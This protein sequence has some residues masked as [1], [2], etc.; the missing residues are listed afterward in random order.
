MIQGLDINSLVT[1]II[2]LFGGGVV[3]IAIKALAEQKKVNA[4]AT[5]TNIKSLLEI[6]QRMNERMAKLEERVANLEQE[7]YKLKSEKL[8]LEKENHRLETLVEKLETENEELKEENCI[9]KMEL[10]E[11]QAKKEVK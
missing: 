11:V 9:L 4:E 6:D 7:N 10:E 1:V 5:N 3:G 8:A 2:S